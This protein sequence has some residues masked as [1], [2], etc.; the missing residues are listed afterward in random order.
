MTTLVVDA[1]VA[2]K[3]V[4]EEQ[5]TP[6]ALALRKSKLI[7]PELLLAECANILWKKARRAEF[8]NDEAFLAA[9]LLQN[10]DVEIVPMRPLLDTATRLAVALDHP[11]YDCIYLALAVARDCPLITA[12]NRLLGRLAQSRQPTLR[13]RAIRLTDAVTP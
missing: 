2:I 9:R 12:D 10:A 7:A 6:E 8:T 11:A 13:A 4:V 5:G 3:W 1:S